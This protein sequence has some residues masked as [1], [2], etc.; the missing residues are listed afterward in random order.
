MT[1]HNRSRA[2]QG[3]RTSLVRGNPE[4]MTDHNRSRAGQGPR[5]SL[6]RG[7]PEG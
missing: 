4:G 5:T 7:N 2:G 3:P 6:V 1:E